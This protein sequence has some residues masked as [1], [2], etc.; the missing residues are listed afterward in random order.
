MVAA[1]LKL[2]GVG[3]QNCW[4]TEKGLPGT[5][6]TLSKGVGVARVWSSIELWQRQWK[7]RVEVWDQP[8]EGLTLF[9]IVFYD[10]EG[11]RGGLDTDR[12]WV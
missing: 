7:L 11:H 2:L 4:R 3:G 12:N 10:H 5:G 9:V 8:R 6:S 1:L